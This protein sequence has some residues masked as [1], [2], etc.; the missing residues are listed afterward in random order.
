MKI[1][2]HVK[3]QVPKITKRRGLRPERSRLFDLTGTSRL[4]GYRTSGSL[5]VPRW[6][7]FMVI[8]FRVFVVSLSAIRSRPGQ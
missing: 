2:Y 7:P 8:P 1:P 5:R 6:S 4:F 3:Q